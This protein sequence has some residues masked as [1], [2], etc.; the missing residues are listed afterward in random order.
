MGAS[1]LHPSKVAL[2]S[3]LTLFDFD[4]ATLN[5][6]EATVDSVYPPIRVMVEFKD[7]A[8]QGDAHRQHCN[9]NAHVSD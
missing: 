5:S 4:E 7:E 3:R 1:S 8:C 9:Y 6:G 2:Q